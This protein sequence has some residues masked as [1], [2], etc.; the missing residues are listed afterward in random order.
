ME[1]S[2]TSGFLQRQMID[3]DFYCGVESSMWLG[4]IG[5]LGFGC[6]TI[7]FLSIENKQN[8]GLI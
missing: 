5:V 4:K 3:D 7:K 8:G 2:E 6:V 1:A